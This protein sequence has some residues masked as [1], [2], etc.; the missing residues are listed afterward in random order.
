MTA[1][2]AVP[3]PVSIERLKRIGYKNPLT[4]AREIRGEKQ[5]A[6]ILAAKAYLEKFIG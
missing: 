6:D 1:V 5:T 4:I 3:L 2:A